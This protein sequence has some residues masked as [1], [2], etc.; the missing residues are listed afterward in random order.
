MVCIFVSSE[1][2]WE[3]SDKEQCL[4]LAQE[5][6]EWIQEQALIYDVNVN[7]E[8]ECLNPDND[9]QVDYFPGFNEY[10]EQTDAVIQEIVQQLDFENFTEF[11]HD[12]KNRDCNQNIHIIFF[13]NQVDRAYMA[14]CDIDDED[15]AIE[16]N[17]MYND[18]EEDKTS[19]FSI[20]HE[21]L[22][23]YG[24]WD[25]YDVWGTD[26]AKI[27][28][29]YVNKHFKDEVMCACVN[30]VTEST[31][32]EFTAFLVG[33]HDNPKK[34]YYK[35]VKES[36]AE[37]LKFIM[38]NY[39][40]FDD[41]GNLII[42]E[43]KEIAVFSNEERIFRRLKI[44]NSEL[45]ILWKEEIAET[46]EIIVYEETSIQDNYYKFT[47]QHDTEEVSISVDNGNCYLYNPETNSYDF[48][49]ELTLGE[50]SEEENDFN[51]EDQECVIRFFN[52][53][54]EFCKYENEENCTVVWKETIYK[55]NEDVLYS[56]TSVD[57]CYFYLSP[58]KGGNDISIALDGSIVY[59]FNPEK[60][61]YLR[62][63]KL[64]QE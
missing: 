40:N 44:N 57:D 53:H 9:I 49:C 63:C 35:M 27:S 30:D 4:E 43:E 29:K 60:N 32:S 11:Y 39:A 1:N 64:E 18:D 24:A 28:E 56:E 58:I 42:H 23:A 36:S 19:T 8:I 3:N 46:G 17:I 48:W 12:I 52:Q 45:F 15:K 61:D 33:W 5:S 2:Q 62:W 38:D 10:G 50:G 16:F 47:S 14:S 31:L 26:D 37:D 6:I 13:I 51:I 25:L 55:T 34:W 59:R 41:D 20:V 22:H 7:I 21:T 54:R